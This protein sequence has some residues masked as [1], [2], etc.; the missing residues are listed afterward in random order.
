MESGRRREKKKG[1]TNEIQE[2]KNKD[3]VKSRNDWKFKV[4]IGKT[5]MTRKVL[6]KKNNKSTDIH[7]WE[8]VLNI[9]KKKHLLKNV[10]IRR[11]KNIQQSPLHQPRIFLGLN[12]KNSRLHLERKFW[13]FIYFWNIAA[14]CS[15]LFFN[16]CPYTL[17]FLSLGVGLIWFFNIWGLFIF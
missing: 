11:A 4:R 8:R 7:F 13:M 16:F 2:N 6:G 10:H 3:K 9:P 17:P 1:K 15:M 14:V 5:R 12:P